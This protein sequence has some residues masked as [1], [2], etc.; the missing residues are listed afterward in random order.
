M[1]VS[2]EKEAELDTY[3]EEF[4]RLVE[5]W[6]KEWLKASPPLEVVHYL[7]DPSGNTKRRL[8]EWSRYVTHR[9]E[10]WWEERGWR[11]HWGATHTDPCRYEPLHQTNEEKTCT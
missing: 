1:P 10:K 8:D 2:A 5:Q 6:K 11:I 4:K 3:L 9:T 7:S